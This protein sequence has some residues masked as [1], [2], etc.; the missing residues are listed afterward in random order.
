MKAVRIAAVGG[1]VGLAGLMAQPLSAHAADVQPTTGS[2]SA[3]ALTVKVAPEA[4]LAVSPALQQLTSQL[5]QLSNL[6]QAGNISLSLDQSNSLGTLTA[7]GRDIASGHADSTAVTLDVAAL[8]NVLGQV[9]A[10]LAVL[11]QALHQLP[12]QALSTVT[13]LLPTD[14]QT[15]LTKVESAVL[16]DSPLDNLLNALGLNVNSTIAA[17]L[18]LAG[19]TDNPVAVADVISVPAGLQ[20]VLPHT[21]AP[22]HATAVNRALAAKNGIATG[23]QVSADNTTTNLAVLGQNLS[24]LTGLNVADLTNLGTLLNTLTDISGT[25]ANVTSG[26]TATQVQQTCTSVV[27]GA[28]GVVAGAIQLP[29]GVGSTVCTTLGTTLATATTSPALTTVVNDLAAALKPLQGTLKSLTSLLPLGNIDL[30]NLVQTKGETSTAM[31]HPTSSGAEAIATTIVPD[32]S[33]LTL[34]A[35]LGGGSLLSLQGVQA[36]TA[37]RFGAASD[38][39]T[40]SIGRL[41]VLGHQIDLNSLAPGQQQTVSL[42]LSSLTGGAL[43]GGLSVII[44][45][46]I[47]QTVMNT[48]TEQDYQISALDVKVVAADS[49]ANSL[50]PLSSGLLGGLGNRA[51]AP[52]RNASTTAGTTIVEISAGNAVTRLAQGTPTQPNVPTTPANPAVQP[53]LPTTGMFGPWALIAG[54]ALG[55]VAIALRAVSSITGR[56]RS[57]R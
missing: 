1:L 6:L 38:T 20:A 49:G 18:G 48:A 41:S 47:G 10:Q 3:S 13:G 2:A 55:A 19:K 31:V 51:A 26:Q 22:F 57:V 35:T 42:S 30:G 29:S 52:A 17:D 23:P 46:G 27:S 25:L 45:R 40:S 28:T 43:T 39:P 53:S 32:V 33:V 5:P 16:S 12:T 34:P 54:G 44:S 56:R 21:I 36:A 9:A 15:L 4:L 50:L 7:D 8:K 11:K 14:L 24:S 37:S